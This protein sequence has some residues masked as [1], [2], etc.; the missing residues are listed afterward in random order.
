MAE[1]ELDLDVDVDLDLDVLVVESKKV[2]LPGGQVVSIKIPD[3]VTLLGLTKM[4]GQLDKIQKGT[5]KLT[6]AQKL[7]MFVEIKKAFIESV[8]ELK[9]YEDQLSDKMV[10]ALLEFVAKISMPN[11]LAELEKRG[12]TLD[13]AQ[14]KAIQGYLDQ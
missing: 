7:A 14:K 9:P 10:V 6:N 1:V 11:D 5:S 12:I 3:L 2:R 4:G 13:D 8:P